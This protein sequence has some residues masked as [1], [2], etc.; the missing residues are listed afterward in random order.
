MELTELEA[1]EVR[2]LRTRILRPHFPDGQR[3]DFQG[4]E[5]PQTTHYGLV[6][7]AGAPAAVVSYI[8][9]PPPF[10]VDEPTIRLRGMA[11]RDGDRGRGLGSRLLQ[12]S[13]TRLA[14][15]Q[16]E[17]AVVWC[18]AR[19]SAQQFYRRHRFETHGEVFE[20]DEIGP[21]IVM[22]RRMPQVVG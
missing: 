11:V 4:D 9:E 2:P 14:V 13:L 20:V 7:E 19:T 3:A 16:S 5:D 12:G 21:H 6:D 1:D 10:D 8:R 17:L 22:W 18:N 15:A